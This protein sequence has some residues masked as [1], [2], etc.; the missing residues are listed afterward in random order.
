MK[1][2]AIKEIRRNRDTSKTGYLSDY[3]GSLYQVV[4]LAW[5]AVITVKTSFM[6]IIFRMEVYE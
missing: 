1:R 6:Y 5:L 3:M 4:Q 2:Q